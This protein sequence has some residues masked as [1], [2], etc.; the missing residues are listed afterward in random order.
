[1]AP[2]LVHCAVLLLSV[3]APSSSFRSLV[4]CA[5]LSSLPKRTAPK[6]LPRASQASHPC[7]DVFQ[8]VGNGH[9]VFLASDVYSCLTNTPFRADIAKDL[10]QYY[11]E[12]LQF[13]STLAYLKNPPAS[14]Q[15][16]GVDLLGGLDLIENEVDLGVYENEYAFEASLRTLI[17]AAHDEHLQFVGGVLDVF[18]FAS[19]LGIVSLSSDGIELPKVYILDDLAEAG[20]PWAPG[21]IVSSGPH[22]W[23]PSAVRSIDNMG[24]T[25]YLTRFANLNSFGHRDRQADWNNLMYSPA[26]GIQDYRTAFQGESPF[27][28][29]DIIEFGFENGTSTGAL[30]SVAVL[31]DDFNPGD[32]P[33]F[34][35]GSDFYNYF[36][37]GQL[38]QELPS[39]NITPAATAASTANASLATASTSSETPS[40][41]AT[42][43]FAVGTA[44]EWW[45]TPA[46]PYANISQAYLGESQGGYVTG[47]FLNSS[48]GVLSIPTFHMIGDTLLQ[49]SNTVGEFLNLSKQAGMTKIVVD[50]QQNFGGDPLLAIDTFKHFFPTRDP[51]IGSRSRAHA[52]ANTLGTVFTDYYEK[53][54]T[55]DPDYPLLAANVWVATDFLNAATGQNFSSWPEYFGPHR[56]HGDQFTT[57]QRYNLSSVDFDKA[58]TGGLIVYGYGPRSTTSPQLYAAEDIIILTDSVCHSACALFVEMMHHEAG[59]RTVVAGGLPQAGEMQAIGGTRGALRYSAGNIDNDID[60]FR[61]SSPPLPLPN[62]TIEFWV[63]YA[64]ITLQ[65]QIRPGEDFPLQFAYEAADCRIFFT[66]DT[67]ADYAA[68]WQRAADAIWTN[69]AFCVQGSTGYTTTIETNDTA[70]S[71]TNQTTYETTV[72]G[73]PRVGA[74]GTFDFEY[75]GPYVDSLYSAS[76]TLFQQCDTNSQCAFDQS[77]SIT[78]VCSREGRIVLQRRCK[79]EC[80]D[81]S[82]CQSPDARHF[83]CSGALCEPSKRP[84]CQPK[85]R[86]NNPFPQTNRFNIPP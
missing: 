86:Y 17:Y 79:Q 43:D 70:T 53:V 85:R 27:Y 1:M 60:T 20:L 66:S 3:F 12:T 23:T 32:L 14:Y 64:G 19:P 71:S 24:V 84:S 7:G 45:S 80:A 31:S 49:F 82:F 25:E 52:M 58:A 50:V 35:N 48:V 21:G 34:N 83:F 33:H 72:A 10:L 61:N 55:N 69:P 38:P 44:A 41:T 37:L 13:Q 75:N 57:T 63:Q 46:Y 42:A 15:Q 9:T 56:H 11:R 8:A 39:A 47:Y 18:N 26:G 28:N 29:G 22:Q 36:V 73:F 68:L 62:R 77:C 2:S 67:F 16:P 6:L 30:K 78:E 40:A 59:V 5:T 81:T 76:Q 4:E 54:D 51:L 65:D 74:I